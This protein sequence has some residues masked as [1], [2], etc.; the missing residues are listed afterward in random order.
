MTFSE[1]LWDKFLTYDNFL[2]AWQ[3]TVNVTSRM[4][5]DELGFKIFAFNLE[6]NLKDLIRQVQAED[7]P[8]TPLADHK[9]YVPK[10]STT[11]RTMSLMAV[12]DVIVYQALVNV[13]ADESHQYLVTHQ[14]Q[15]IFG[16]IYAGS[17]KRWMLR[18]W[19]QQY[20][21]FV[22][23]VE[24]LYR[25][26]NS[27]IASTDI[28]SF[29]DTIDH[30][31]LIQ[32]VRKYC[33]CK[34]YSKFE[35]LLKE[36]LSKWS[37]H[38]ADV[39]MSRGIPQ[40]SNAS[41]FLAN[42]FL[43]ELDKIMICQGYNYVRYVDDIRILGRDKPTV[44]QGLILFDLELKRAGLVAQVTKTSLHEIED[45]NKEITHLRF[46]I[47][48]P[49]GEGEYTLIK[50][51]TI[52]KSEQAELA[53]DYVKQTTTDSIDEETK[54]SHIS[55]DSDE[56]CDDDFEEEEG[57][58]YSSNRNLNIDIT[59]NGKLQEQ[60]RE[61]F[62]EG[63]S[64]LNNSDK[65]KEAESNI[66]F[67]LYRLEPHESIREPILDLLYRLPWRSE[68]VC[69]CLGRFKNDSVIVEGLQ[70][71]INEHK[72][73][74]WHRANSLWSLYQISGAKN[75][76]F[77]CREWLA[78]N[79]LDWYARMIAARILGK[80]PGQYSYFMECLQQEQHN[81][82]DDPESSSLLRQELAYSA[83]QRIKSHNKLL[84][85]F[86]LIC[87]DKS[88][89]M[90]RLAIYLLQMNKCRVTW[91]DLKP[92]HQEMSKLSDLVRDVNLSPNALKICFIYQT[93]STMYNI[94]LP[95]TNLRLFYGNHY[96]RA[97]DQ[98]RESV[99]SYH[100]SPNAYIR[101]FHQFAH[102]T[103]IAFYEYTFPSESGLHDGYASLTDRKVFTTSLPNGYETWKELG[104]MR[105]RVDHPVDKKTK[106]H[107]KK[108]TIE[109]T[110]FFCKK[111][112]VA[113]QEIFNFWLKSSPVT[114]TSVPVSTT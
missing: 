91:D 43:H 44:Q 42:L 39:K 69:Y 95:T 54:R 97:V 105:N 2:L 82:K 103:L 58:R 101:T 29:Y 85:L 16:N 13:I 53:A 77:I 83:F 109:E 100:K 38:T 40:G 111:L 79:R 63:Y 20:N 84:T 32:L 114:T 59:G 31:R 5:I 98:L 112:N 34:R 106:S 46:I 68:A 47:T 4:I 50:E 72:V 113:L 60:L 48:D 14:N 25:Q 102:L 6:A 86:R 89:V 99:S 30:E 52:P 1:N 3:R 90:H 87:T 94:F 28:V 70:N 56:D 62:L 8:Y 57:E 110:E 74:S 73:Y 12:P 76:A 108:I 23:S 55:T 66:T 15:H 33:G 9:V 10:P 24:K 17:G 49:T 27:W 21:N 78:D 22:N 11:L 107:S 71:F 61:T 75:S 93:L 88:S 26:G 81:S 19:K 35:K 7:F 104:S 51:P 41:D 37:A 18:P 67:C 36:C 45:I 80:L 96:E 92:Y 65:S 64:L